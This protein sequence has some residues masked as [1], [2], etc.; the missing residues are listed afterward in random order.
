MR[1]SPVGVEHPRDV[2]VQSPHHADARMHQEVAAFGGA[3]QAVDSSLL[4]GMVLLC[5]GQ[6]HD[7]GGG[8]LERDKLATVRQRDRFVKRPPPS[9]VGLQW[10]QPFLSTFVLKLFGSLGGVPS[11]AAL[12]SGQGIPDP[13]QVQARSPSHGFSGCFSHTQPQPSHREHFIQRRIPS[14]AWK[15]RL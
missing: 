14:A 12:Q 6:L 1:V 13:P 8:I 7:V 4:V 9:F 15:R 11:S 2:P 5:L 10:R 3:D